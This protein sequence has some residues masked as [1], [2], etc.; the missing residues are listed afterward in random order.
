MRFDPIPLQQLSKLHDLSHFHVIFIDFISK[1]KRVPSQ[2]FFLD[3][4]SPLVKYFFAKS[5][6]RFFAIIFLMEI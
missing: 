5:V 4:L 3:A 1:H 2:L 6:A